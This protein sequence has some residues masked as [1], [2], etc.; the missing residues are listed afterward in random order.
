L[1]KDLVRLAII[2]TATR[3]TP[4]SYTHLIPLED[5]RTYAG[6]IFADID[7]KGL[8]E[9]RDTNAFSRNY[10]I[11]D[12]IVPVKDLGRQEYV[13]DDYG[14]MVLSTPE[15]PALYRVPKSI[16]R[17]VEERGQVALYAHPDYGKHASY[18]VIKSLT[19]AKDP[20]TGK[21]IR[22]TTLYQRVIRPTTGSPLTTPDGGYI[23]KQVNAWGK[24]QYMQEY[25][26]FGHQSIYNNDT[27]KV[28]EISDWDIVN[29]YDGKGGGNEQGGI[30]V[31]INSPNKPITYGPKNG[32]KIKDK[33]KDNC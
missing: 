4:L 19:F 16:R 3:K 26:T 31:D 8:D 18:P 15:T 1:Y 9:F 24:G 17:V 7:S 33:N 2:Q 29:A 20:Q 22:I 32:P 11:D 13:M 30:V 23:Y 21:P 28:D 10:W 12:D 5:Y 27:V 14:N 25:Y 6:D